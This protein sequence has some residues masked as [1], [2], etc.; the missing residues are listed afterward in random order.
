MGTDTK[1]SPQPVTQPAQKPQQAETPV[2]A[3]NADPKRREAGDKPETEPSTM[4][5]FKKS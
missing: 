2:N 4:Q 5:A 3:G 1:K